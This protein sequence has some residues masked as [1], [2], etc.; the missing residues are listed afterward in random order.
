[1]AEDF[2]IEYNSF[3]KLVQRY[4]QNY[5]QC[6]SPIEFSKNHSQVHDL[7]KITQNT[8]PTGS[9]GHLMRM[10]T[11]GLEGGQR[12][13]GAIGQAGQVTKVAFAQAGHRSQVPC[14]LSL[15]LLVTWS[16]QVSD[17]NIFTR[18]HC[19]IVATTMLLIIATPSSMLP[20]SGF[21]G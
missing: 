13:A 7:D 21:D 6:F 4:F 5:I 8:F 12:G 3:K 1:M 17:G 11:G 9:N 10:G 16:K 2:L 18:W 19:I 14:L 20:L 15:P